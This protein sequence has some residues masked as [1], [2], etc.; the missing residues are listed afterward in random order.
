MTWIKK[1]D[2]PSS[3]GKR[4]YVVAIKENGE[5]GCSCPAWKF[6]RRNC[7]HIARI[8][9]Q[10]TSLRGNNIANANAFH[11]ASLK[12]MPVVKKAKTE[13]NIIQAQRVGRKFNFD[14]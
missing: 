2:V 1:W 12:K 7:K 8:Q 4:T 14:E 11:G 3:D 5:Y 6:H 10:E 9:S 13:G